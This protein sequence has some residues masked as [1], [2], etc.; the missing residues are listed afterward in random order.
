MENLEEL[1][2][3]EEVPRNYKEASTDERWIEAMK[4]E[5][6]SINKN[7]T[8]KLTTLPSDHK[9]I[10]L[11]SVFKMKKDAKRNIVKYKARLVEKGYVREH[12]IDF[13]EV[14][15]PVARIKTG[16]LILVLAAYH[17]WEVH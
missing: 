3:V 13:D 1:M 12:G 9:A 2:M 15:A 8:W 4:D 6:D 11:K 16:R 10:G 7:N 17:G 5:L 14:F